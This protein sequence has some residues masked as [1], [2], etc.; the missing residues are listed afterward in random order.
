MVVNI[1]TGPLSDNELIR[2]ARH[3]EDIVLEPGALDTVAR[4]LRGA[5]RPA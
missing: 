3:G 5:P 2:I 4:L 1:G